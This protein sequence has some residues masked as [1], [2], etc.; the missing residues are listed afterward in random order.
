[1]DERKFCVYMFTNMVN[2]KVYVGQTQDLQGRIRSHRTKPVKGMQADVS[3]M[4]WG[5]FKL[6]V[7][8]SGLSKAEAKG[9]ERRCITQHRAIAL[10][11]QPYLAGDITLFQAHH[12]LSSSLKGG[13]DSDFDAILL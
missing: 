1:M 12:L 11:L 4:G 5:V 6:T 3:A 2:Q 8:Q 13:K 7:I 9:L 10:W